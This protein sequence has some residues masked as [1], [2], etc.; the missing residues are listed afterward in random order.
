[1]ARFVRAVPLA[2]LLLCGWD[3]PVSGQWVRA[4]VGA[5][6]GVAGGAV[7]TVSAIVFR[8]RFQEEYIDSADDLI[9]WQTIPM[10]A[11]PAAGI[12]FGLAGEEA[13][14]GSII[15]STSGMAAGAAIGAGLGWLLSDQQESPWA[16]GVIGAGVGLTLG[17][18][19]GGLLGASRRSDDE[20]GG[21]A[22]DAVRIGFSLPVP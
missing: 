19:A 15:G 21:S 12:A 9:H 8:A 20:S 6:V 22:P 16:G 4:A 14:M 7:V 17:G 1:M 10:I 18:L 3:V 11:A 5:G 13:Q 2:L